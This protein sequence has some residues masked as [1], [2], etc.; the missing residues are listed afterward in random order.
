MNDDAP[1]PRESAGWEI[2]STGASELADKLRAV[3]LYEDKN[4]VEGDR[5]RGFIARQVRHVA[6][7]YMR[8]FHTWKVRDVPIAERHKQQQEFAKF[9]EFVREFL[10]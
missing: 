8:R 3:E 1:T 9:S 4:L 2:W 6:E 10:K 7:S 5:A